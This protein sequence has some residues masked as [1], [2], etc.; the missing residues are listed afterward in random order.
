LRKDPQNPYNDPEFF[1]ALGRIAESIGLTWGGRFKVGKNKDQP[2]NPHVQAIIPKDQYV[3]K[4]LT[5]PM[6]RNE[7]IRQRLG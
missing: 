6:A 4:K 7:F 3:V 2:D 1:I 5:D